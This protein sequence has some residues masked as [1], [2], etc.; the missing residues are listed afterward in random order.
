MFNI[1][2]TE[3]GGKPRTEEFDQNEV[4]IGR[5]Q[6][7]DIV[8]AKGNIS[9]RH[10]RIVLRDGKFI[11]VDLKSTNGTF[12]NGKR[13]NS[14]Q[15]LKQVDKIYIG[16]F[17]LTVES[18][19]DDVEFDD[20][21][22][23][24][25]PAP[26]PP[27][28]APPAPTP[29]PAGKREPEPE[30]A[31]P[32]PPS[33][34]EDVLFPDAKP[35]VKPKA[36][37]TPAPKRPSL[38][39]LPSAAALDARQKV[40]ASVLK[41][42]GSLEELPPDDDT[43]FKKAEAA[44]AKTLAVFA[45]KNTEIPTEEWAIEIAR[46]VCNTGPIQTLL[47]DAEVDEIF[48]NGPH[49]VVVRR[50]G[51]LEGVSLVLSSEDA[52]RLVAQRMM[53]NAGV[54]FDAENPVGE[55]RL[56]DGTRVSAAHGAVTVGGPYIAVTRQSH[57][58]VDLAALVGEGVLSTAMAEFVRLCIRAK[59]NLVVVG[60]PSA[61]TDT[62]VAAIASEIG[63]TERI[64]LVQRAGQIRLPQAHVVSMQASTTGNM[65]QIVQHA[66]RMRPDR[67][68]VHEVAAGEATDLVVS[69]GGGQV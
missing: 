50:N 59:R 13:I 43:T 42:L 56:P 4:T 51:E 39:A 29:P 66:L 27:A 23:P 17:T 25:P 10:S 35:I 36:S 34:G 47:D 24:A 30:P 67:L 41:A 64:L 18:A 12:V 6:G 49:Q 32:A 53:D 21:P 60:G 38:V 37:P 40:F 45:K 2:I 65:R 58:G 16:D 57:R 33:A 61:D 68:V 54:R 28:P 55:C 46:E 48:I 3:K 8:L 15:V 63:I 5:V 1:V 20:P 69:M 44:A 19:D 7:N 22:E 52:V 14:P 11:I 31:P 62:L 9:K 26:A